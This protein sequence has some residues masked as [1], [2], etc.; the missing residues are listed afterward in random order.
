MESDILQFDYVLSFTDEEATGM[1]IPQ[2]AWD[3]VS[4]GIHLTLVGRLLS[5]RSVQFEA[6]KGALIQLIQAAHGLTVR[7]VSEFRFRLVFAHVEDL[8]RVLE[9]RPWIFDRNLVLLQPLMQWEDPLLVNLGWCP[10][11]V[12]IHDLRYGQRSVEVVCY[13][14][15]FLGCL[16]E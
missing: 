15:R 6:L 9:L 12:H 13:I 2:T 7:K 4:S 11:I 16:V 1:L 10:F 5:H 14:G 3:H 8:R